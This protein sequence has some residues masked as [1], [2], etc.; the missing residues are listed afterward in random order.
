MLEQFM[1]PGGYTC[2]EMVKQED[3][4]VL[5]FSGETRAC[6]DGA[7]ELWR[8]AFHPPVE[9]MA[10]SRLQDGRLIGLSYDDPKPAEVTV[11]G[12]NGSTFS[13]WYSKDSG[14]SWRSAGPVRE[15]RLLLCAQRPDLGSPRGAS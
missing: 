2:G 1:T 13:L 15:S 3:G 10:I 12:L 9:P 14:E 8:T 6:F 4:T 7:R 11:A 5:V